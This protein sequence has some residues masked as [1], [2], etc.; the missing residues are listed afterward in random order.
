M[1]GQQLNPHRYVFPF[2]SYSRFRL[3]AAIFEK[4]SRHWIRP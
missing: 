3:A 1:W 4:R 2:K